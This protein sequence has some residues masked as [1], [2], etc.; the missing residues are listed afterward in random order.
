M[1][2]LIRPQDTILTRNMGEDDQTSDIVQPD[3]IMVEVRYTVDGEACYR[4]KHVPLHELVK[5]AGY[6]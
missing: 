3:S 1:D 4:H 2:I 5:E 6:L